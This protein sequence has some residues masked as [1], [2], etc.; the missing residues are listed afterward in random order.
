M[1]RKVILH[2]G[3][4]KTGTSYLQDVLFKNKRLLG[5]HGILY[6][7][8]RF[9]AHFLAALDLMRLP[10]GG[11]EREAVGA[12]DRLAAEVRDWGGTTAVI[13]HEILA[14]RLAVAGRARA[15]V[16]RTPA[17]RQRRRGA[18][19]ALGA[20]PGPPDP[21]RVAGERQA[22]QRDE[23]RP[24][25]RA[26]HRPGPQQ[27]DRVV[28]LERP[29]GAR[30]PRPLGCGPAA[31]AD[32]PGDRPVPGGRARPAVEAVLAG[33]RPRGH[34]PGP[35]GRAGQPVARRP[36]DGADPP[37]QPLGQP[38]P[39]A[40]RLPPARPRAARAPDAVAPGAVAA[41]GPAAGAGAVG[42]RARGGVRRRDRAARLRRRRRPPRPAGQPDAAPVRRPRQAA[43]A[44]RRRRRRRR[45]Q[46]AAAR[47]RPD[48]RRGGPAPGAS[49]TRPVTR[50][51]ARTCGRPTGPA[52]RP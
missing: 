5:E 47:E 34:R 4:P 36:R 33:V 45:D 26:D 3:T 19:G 13:S 2:V 35:R 29:G 39:R 8:D 17:R 44:R 28:V 21:G 1:T 10:W 30:D 31:R 11:L 9:D 24:V 12:W 18:P 22:P 6:P 41:A 7:A 37:D 51:R 14:G 46:G 40:R 16:A 15:G 38:R 25:P 52:R 32:P 27:P 49:S 23:L 48:A 43:R 20:R 50:C 42:G